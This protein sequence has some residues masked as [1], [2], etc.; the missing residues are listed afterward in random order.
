MPKRKSSAAKPGTA[1]AAARS[2][3]RLRRTTQGGLLA[4]S[5]TVAQLG[6]DE[7]VAGESF[8][9]RNLVDRL[10]APLTRWHE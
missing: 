8:F 5:L 9:Q 7:T 2:A 6:W 10:E 3:R 1:M 4:V